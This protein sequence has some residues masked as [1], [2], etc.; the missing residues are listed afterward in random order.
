MRLS[1]RNVATLEAAARVL[2]PPGGIIEPGADELRLVDAIVADVASWPPRV[3]SRIKMLL[4]AVE[5]LPFASGQRR[6]FRAL[7]PD[8]QKKVL[9]RNGHHSFALRRLVVSRLKQLVL[10]AYLCTPEVEEAV[11][12]RYECARPRAGVIG[13]QTH[14]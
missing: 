2:V 6:S 4:V 3:R 13:E 1:R 9:E 12:Y 10:T 11:G 5:M 14:H 7:D 8:V